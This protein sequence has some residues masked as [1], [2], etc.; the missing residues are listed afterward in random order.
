[1][2]MPG[3]GLA[4]SS[5]G[6]SVDPSWDL[7]QTIPSHPFDVHPSP[8]PASPYV[9]TTYPADGATNV[10]LS[11]DI[12]ITF[13]VPM[14]VSYTFSAISAAPSIDWAYKW[15]DNYMTITLSPSSSVLQ[16][17]TWYIIGVSTAAMSQTGS[18]DRKSTRLNS[19]H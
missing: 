16:Y 10:P 15:S 17:D 19:S 4:P 6:S 18:Q 3:G 2:M 9:V 11:S 13:D 7:A 5:E 8:L 1:M 14:E 12:V